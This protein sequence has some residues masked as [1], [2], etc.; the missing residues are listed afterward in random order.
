LPGSAWATTLARS[1]STLPPSRMISRKDAKRQRRR[2]IVNGSYVPLRR[3]TFA[4]LR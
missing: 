2:E 4:T 1:P 3:C